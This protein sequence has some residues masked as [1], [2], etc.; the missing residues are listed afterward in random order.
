[1]AACIDGNV[2]DPQLREA[3]RMMGWT[4]PA[5]GIECAKG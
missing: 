2:A 3:L 5:S 1:M 4:T